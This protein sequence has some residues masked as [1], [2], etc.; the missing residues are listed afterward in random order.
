MTTVPRAAIEFYG[1]DRAKFLG[2]CP[3]RLAQLPRTHPFGV[4]V[5]EGGDVGGV[6]G[7]SCLPLHSFCQNQN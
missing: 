4:G 2:G 7:S 3:L 1:P 6:E 5:F